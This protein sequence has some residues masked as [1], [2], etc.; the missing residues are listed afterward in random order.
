MDQTIANLILAWLCVLQPALAFAFGILVGRHGFKHAL[1]LAL[2]K[3]FGQ[4]PADT[5]HGQ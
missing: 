5:E 2:V 1:T 4:P 3:I